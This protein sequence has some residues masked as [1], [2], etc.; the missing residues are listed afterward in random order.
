MKWT[1]D[2]SDIVE[3]TSL[4]SQNTDKST[5]VK[6]VGVDEGPILH[7]FSIQFRNGNSLELI[8]SSREEYVHW[9]D[10]IHL[11][12]N[13]EFECEENLNDFDVLTSAE[14]IVKLME[15][16]GVKLP[17]QAPEIPPLP[18]NYN[19]YMMDSK[20]IEEQRKQK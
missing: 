13:K 16:E 20:E 7:G 14:M 8:A 12:L 10:G 15:L 6:K 18:S 2:V 3:V 17:T 4:S 19:F 9:V 5:K 1:G 11:L